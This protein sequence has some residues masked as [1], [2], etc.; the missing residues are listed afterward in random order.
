MILELFNKAF[1][2]IMLF[3]ILI[4]LSQRKI[5]R[6]VRK[7]RATL[8]IAVDLLVLYSL[9]L[10]ISSWSLPSYL[11][12]VAVIIAIITLI[13][14]RRAVWPF[15]F[16]CRTC[17]AKLDYNHIIGHDENQCTECW[18][19]E[20]PE[21]AEKERRKKMTREDML[22]EDFR[23]AEK[24]DDID[25]QRW[26]PTERCVLTYITD[27]SRILLIEKKRGLGEGYLNGPGGHIEL[28]E[29]K[30][31]AAIRETKEETGLDVSDLEERGCLYFNFKDGLRMIGYV[32]F[33]S[34]WSGNL[35][36]ECDE[37]RPFWTDVSTLDYKRMWEDDVLWLPLALEGKK[38]EGYFIFDDLKMLDHKVV[39]VEDL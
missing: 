5:P 15:R 7:S 1:T 3:I 16:K 17:G 36:E 30:V 39:E 10:A 34:S 31:E 32:F 13:I 38:F 21:D 28:E 6:T 18:N 29:T 20:H 22:E 35:I 2:W 8:L 33:T 12:W 14:F 26:E 19:K 9:L 11:E 23:K 25:W 27:G 4:N 24:V 37:T